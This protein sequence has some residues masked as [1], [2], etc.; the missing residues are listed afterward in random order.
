MVTI[1]TTP[2]SDLHTEIVGMLKAINPR[3][4]IAWYDTYM[5][6]F[7]FL[8]PDTMWKDEWDAFG[9]STLRDTSGASFPWNDVNNLWFDTGAKQDSIISIW[10]FKA[11]NGRVDRDH[12]ELGDGRY[13]AGVERPALAERGSN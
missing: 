7:T 3:I 5:Q 6:R 1:N 13:H 11:I 10:R 8:N 12:R 2:F 9:S 4:I